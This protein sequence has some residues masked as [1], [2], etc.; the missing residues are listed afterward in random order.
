MIPSLPNDRPFAKPNLAISQ[1]GTLLESLPLQGT[2][3]LT[4]GLAALSPP[5]VLRE[6]TVTLVAAPAGKPLRVASLSV[7]IVFLSSAGGLAVF[8]TMSR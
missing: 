1:I 4:G 7:T 5:L 2:V 6:A 3:A 8:L